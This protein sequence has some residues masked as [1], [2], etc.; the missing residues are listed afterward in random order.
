[1][2]AKDVCFGQGAWIE[3]QTTLDVQR[4]VTTRNPRVCGNGWIISHRLP[5]LPKQV[6]AIR[7]CLKLANSLRTLTPC[8]AAIDC[9]TRG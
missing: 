6:Q 3:G 2:T 8:N 1:M 4:L 7:A 5:Q 9:N